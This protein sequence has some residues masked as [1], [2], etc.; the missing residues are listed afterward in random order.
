MILTI[1]SVFGSLQSEF[2]NLNEDQRVILNLVY[3]KGKYFDLGYTMA[4]IAWQES[5]FGKVPINL[6]DP[7]CGIFHN[8]ITT[9]ANRHN[10]KLTSYNKNMICMR[11]IR[12][13][14]FSFAEALSELKYWQNYYHNQSKNWQSMVKS[15]NAGFKKEN[16]YEYFK[17]IQKKVRFLK[18]S[19]T[20]TSNEK[21]LIFKGD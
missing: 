9:V 6:S 2:N 14:D 3:D 1:S 20:Q 17:A 12:D 10:L 5:H 7:S 19:Y 15:Y 21:N 16:G 11:L 18:K 8:L 13:F 4:A